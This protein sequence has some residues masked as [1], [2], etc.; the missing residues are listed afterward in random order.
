ME[1]EG[2]NS[3]QMDGWMPEGIWGGGKG[4]GE[5]RRWGRWEWVR[6]REEIDWKWENKGEGKWG[7][8]R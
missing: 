8:K 5:G 4:G 2:G 7:G 3:G 1:G 6:R